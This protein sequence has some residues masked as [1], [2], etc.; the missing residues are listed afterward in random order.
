MLLR[1]P[2]RSPPS[3]RAPYSQR[4]VSPWRIA[5]GNRRRYARKKYAAWLRPT[6]R[7]GSA[8][9]TR[10]TG[11]LGEPDADSGADSG[12]TPGANRGASGSGSSDVWVTLGHTASMSPD[13]RARRGLTPPDSQGTD[14]DALEREAL[15][16]TGAAPLSSAA[17]SAAARA[18]AALP[19]EDSSRYELEGVHARGGLGRVVRAHDRLLHRTVA[20]K[21]LLQ[22]TPSAQARFMREALITARLQ[23]PGIVPVH[24]AGRWPSGDPYYSMKL[25]SGRT[26]KELIQERKSLDERMALLPHVLAVA[27]AIAYAHSQGVIHRDIKPANV[28]V[29]DFGETVVVD[30]GLAKDLSGSGEREAN[31]DG[32]AEVEHDRPRCRPGRHRGRPHHGHAGVHGAGAGA[33][34]EHRRARRRLLARRAALRAPGRRAAAHR[35]LGR[36]D[37]AQRADRGAG[38]GRAAPAGRA[39]RPGRHRAQ[40]DGPPRHR[41]LPLGHRAGRGRAP[42]PDRPAGHRAPLLHAHAGAALDRAPPRRGGGGGRRGRGAGHHRGGRVPA[43]RRPAQPGRGPPERGGQGGA[44]GARQAE[45]AHL[46]AGAELAGARSDDGPGLAQAVPAGRPARR[47]GR[48]HGRSGDRP[49][50]GAPHPAPVDLAGVG[51]LLARGE[52]AARSAQE[53]R[54]LALGRRDRR[55]APARQTLRQRQG[56]GPIARRAHPGAGRPGRRDRAFRCRE[57]RGV[58]PAAQPRRPGVAARLLG[59]RDPPDV[60]GRRPRDPRVG[61]DP[62]GRSQG[63]A[64]A[65]RRR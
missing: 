39:A 63:G 60:A 54:D 32:E 58:A 55:A 40:G 45:R 19:V 1:L 35:R 26:L 4:T 30:W 22:R 15:A 6:G 46:P 14:A 16:S 44:R 3:D 48:R 11:P 24:E 38:A 36:Q 52:G 21:E 8:P 50:R 2:M 29:G 18:A 61:P 28:V 47:E 56:G 57:R 27:E 12:A 34:R 62:G 37:P 20:I 42:L 9:L 13:E 5:A 65:R 23:H 51:R 17:S 41:P 10:R 31:G 53:R 43:R 59:R 64:A 25:V 7:T 33:R 49:G